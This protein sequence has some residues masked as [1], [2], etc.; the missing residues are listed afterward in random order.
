MLEKQSNT[1]SVL[2]VL[3]KPLSGGEGGWDTR[4][5]FIHRQSKNSSEVAFAMGQLY[6]YCL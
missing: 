2:L 5:E 4:V 1:H 6:N 3:G